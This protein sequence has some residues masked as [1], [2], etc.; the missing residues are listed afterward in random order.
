MRVVVT[1]V[2]GYSPASRALATEGVAHELRD[3]R[4]DD[5]YSLLLAE[6]WRGGG[7]FIIVE[8]DVIPWPGAVAGLIDCPRPW[9]SHRAPVVGGAL[10]LS[11][12]AFGK[13]TTTV[14][15]ATPDLPER[16]GSDWRRLDSTIPGGIMEALGESP[17]E[18]DPP[19]AHARTERGIPGNG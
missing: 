8:H 2:E 16:W 18:H 11:T 6:L 10:A 14:L 13:F 17:H 5:S 4:D 1:R 19:V 12:I 9:C 7:D 15:D 3:V